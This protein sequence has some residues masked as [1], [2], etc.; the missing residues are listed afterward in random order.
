MTT[1]HVTLPADTLRRLLHLRDLTD[2]AQG[3]H[4]VQLVVER[5]ETA[6]AAAARVPLHRH[7]LSPVVPVEDNYDRLGYAPD[8]AA[9]DARYSRYLRDDLMLRAH[10]SAA[11]PGL[12][13]RIAAGELHV[14]E[15]DLVLSVPGLVYRRDVVDRHHVGEPH[16]LDVWRLRRG[17]GPALGEDELVAHISTVVEA[18]LPGRPW[19]TEPREHPYTTAGR[20]VDVRADDGAWVEVGECG[21]T[22]PEVLRRAGL[23]P[24]V[25]SGLAMGLGLDRLVMLAKRIDDIRLLRATDPRIV[26]QLADLST[27]E[28]VS[29]MP[30]VR[31][32]LSVAVGPGLDD[33]LLGD[34]VRD[35]LG[36]AARSVETI[37]V[38]ARTPVSD[39]PPAAS[40]RLGAS[41]DQV[42]VLVR[43]TLR[44]LDRTLTSQEA[45][46]LRDRV[47][48]AL[49][50]GSVH[51]WACGH[52]PTT[53]GE[54]GG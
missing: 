25:A 15:P 1:S 14:G 17:A 50:E 32:D 44:D 27:Y 5:I 16:Q 30:A 38:R 23:D 20:Q 39:L 13:E 29:S 28:P 31:R 26:A 8:A 9:R 37:E 49:H 10:T 22:H 41:P 43:L 54:R 18:V 4:A 40:E 33:E 11:M 21:L 42:N 34:R 7:R 52:P 53:E 48:A 6:L 36:E 19:R 45:N 35:A 46:T 47:Y 24:A 3:R 12:H 51:R 2:P